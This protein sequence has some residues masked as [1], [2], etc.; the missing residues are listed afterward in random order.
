MKDLNVTDIWKVRALASMCF[1]HQN[2]RFYYG[3][4]RNLASK[5]MCSERLIQ[6]VW[7]EFLAVINRDPVEW[8]PKVIK[9][10]GMTSGLTE[11]LASDIKQIINDRRGEIV[12]NISYLTS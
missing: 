12:D 8:D 4:L 5:L 3:R 10:P 11:E 6:D 7:G 2:G 9:K 1:D